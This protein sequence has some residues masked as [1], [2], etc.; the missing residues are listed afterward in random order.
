MALSFNLEYSE[1]RL[2][3]VLYPELLSLYYPH[4][5]KE[6]VILW[7]F[8]A[9]QAKQ[10]S[11]T[12][13]QELAGETR[14][15]SEQF[16]ESFATLIQYG[17]VSLFT[18]PDGTQKVR[19][20]E[21]LTESEFQ[22]AYPEEPEVPQ[23]PAQNETAASVEISQ[24]EKV[25]DPFGDLLQY[26]ES[27]VGWI[28]AKICDQL[29]KWVDDGLEPAVIK[30]AV[31]E[32]MK[33]ADSPRFAYLNAILLSWHKNGW[34]SLQDV[35]QAKQKKQSLEGMPNAAAYG[36]PDLERIRKWKELYPDE[37]DA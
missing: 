9:F 29:A 31:D 10:R 8:L 17:L 21:P 14:L 23:M 37:Y 24:P 20:H 32:M 26:Y 18:E 19:I 4:I 30:Q 13:A 22:K 3:L 16:D 5:G 33:K 1:E 27:K 35:E 12:E 2:S 6:G 28:T 25:A 15:T 11:I 7:L 36:A 34:H